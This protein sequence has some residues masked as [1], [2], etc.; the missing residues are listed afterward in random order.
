[1]T[2]NSAASMVYARGVLRVAAQGFWF[3]A[4]GDKGSFGFYPHL[5]DKRG[6]P[7]FPDTQIHGDLKMAASWL[8]NLAPDRQGV[9]LSRIFGAGGGDEAGR[10]STP[11]CLYLG[12]LQLSEESAAQWNHSRFAVKPRIRIDDE[13]RTVSKHFL[14]ALEMAFL[15]GLTLTAPL[16]LGPLPEAELTAA[17]GFVREAAHFLSGF[18]AFRSRGYGRGTADIIWEEKEMVPATDLKD[19]AGVIS[20]T[21]LTHVRNRPIDPGSVQT[22][23]SGFAISPEQFKGWLARAFKDLYGHWPT[24][25]QMA[26]IQLTPLY[27]SPRPGVLTFPPP[28]STLRNEK[29]KIRDLQ[30]LSPAERQEDE[31]MNRE[32]ENF[33]ATKTKNLKPGWFVTDGTEAYEFLAAARMRNKMDNTTFRTTLNGLFV[34]EY[35]EQGTVFSGRINLAGCEETFA[36]QLR[37]VFRRFFPAVKGALFALSFHEQ[38]RRTGPTHGVNAVLAVDTIPY[39]QTLRVDREAAITLSTQRQYNTTLRRPRRP[40]PVVL[41]G[42]VFSTAA[43]DA[44]GHKVVYWSGF[45]K[46]IKQVSA[47]KDTQSHDMSDTSGKLPEVDAGLQ[48]ELKK[49]TR[50]QAGLLR[51]MLHPKYNEKYLKNILDHRIAKYEGREESQGHLKAVLESIKKRL[52]E[53]GRTAMNDHIK[54]LLEA[55]SLIQWE[56]KRGKGVRS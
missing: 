51:E 52:E 6:L 2:N 20:L 50:A 54:A 42:S 41:P 28:M 26:S 23:T 48:R 31:E 56:N 33:F 13:T 25:A 46:E 17:K 32:E 9:D 19:L 10:T 53:G 44:Y 40:R 4:G 39:H 14:V 12:D 5:R 37:E 34:Q 43:L 36:C 11:S 8:Q 21:A 47:G 35:L 55:F 16:F 29:G 49:F 18:G 15:H 7:V 3:T 30:G 1:M 38:E 22:I 24:P 27:P 45:Q